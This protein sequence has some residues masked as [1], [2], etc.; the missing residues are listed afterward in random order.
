M[1]HAKHV[2]ENGLSTIIINSED[3]DVFILCIAYK[4]VIGSEVNLLPKNSKKSRVTYVDISSVCNSLGHSTCRALPALHAFT[5]CGSVSS[6]TGRDKI[7]VLKLLIASSSYQKVLEKSGTDWSQ[8]AETVKG[9][10]HFT[11]HL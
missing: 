3:M 8:H 1:L 11:C 4:D 7:S 6:F 5:G 10:K 9:I 2:K